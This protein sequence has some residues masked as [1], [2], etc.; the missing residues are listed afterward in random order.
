[1]DFSS[2]KYPFLKR[3]CSAAEIFG[4]AVF[5]VSL[6]SGG[7]PSSRTINPRLSRNLYHLGQDYYER[8]VKAKTPAEKD[9]FLE[10]SL[11]QLRNSV[12]HDP[13][14]YLARNLLGYLYLQRADQE[15]GMSEVSQCLRGED[16]EE[17]RANAVKLF[18][19][20]EEQF[21]GVVDIEPKCTN[22]WLGL[23]NTAMFF[24][25]YELAIKHARKVINTLIEGGVESACS[26]P[27]DQAVA[28]ANIGWAHFQMGDKI[29][30]SKNL[31][32]AIFLAPKFYL[33]HYWMGRVHYSENRYEDAFKEFEMTAREFGLPQA[34]H[35]YLGLTKLKLGRKE[36]AR[37]AFLRCVE[38][39]PRSCTAEE[40]HRYLK[41]MRRPD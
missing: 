31:R 41:I 13:Q 32:Q 24:N 9:R 20:A 7:C 39:A 38:L 3:F 34:V 8:A 12:K 33:A 23:T 30:A 26:S 28:W 27:G 5:L 6:M 10:E 29:R 40:C 25:S 21:R 2:G 19:M 15:L 22:S 17:T 37:K 14:N 35:Q 11:V 16:A 36:G 1:M 18:K 4:A